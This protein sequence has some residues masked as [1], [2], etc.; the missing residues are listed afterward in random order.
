MIT[1]YLTEVVTRFNPFLPSARA[2]RIFLTNIPAEAR[3]QM[4]VS[5]TVLPKTSVETPVLE[6]KFKDG[7]AMKMDLEQMKIGDV[8]EQV[9]RHSR[10]LA[11]KESIASA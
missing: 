9:D 1:R 8:V 4:R 2:A 7:T 6:I 10:I 11:R 3:L 5:S